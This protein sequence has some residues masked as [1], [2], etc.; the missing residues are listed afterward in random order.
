MPADS[1]TNK[2]LGPRDRDFEFV[3]ERETSG[4]RRRIGAS[5]TVSRHAIY[6]RR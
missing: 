3:T 5:R 2:I 4:D 6:K 1:A